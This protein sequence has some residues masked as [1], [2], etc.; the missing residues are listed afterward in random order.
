MYESYIS[1]ECNDVNISG[2]N[3]SNDNNLIGKANN[4][5]MTNSNTPSS[6][7]C[8]WYTNADS[9]RNKFTEL[10][11]RIDNAQTL[12]AIIAITEAKS[13]KQQHLTLHKLK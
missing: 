2:S 4:P 13:K 9:L 6:K 1:N 5:Q 10:K 11:G 12:P 3:L 7:F 8:C